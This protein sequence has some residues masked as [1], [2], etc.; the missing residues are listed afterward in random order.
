M[1]EWPS[2]EVAVTFPGVCWV[3]RDCRV[4]SGVRGRL[5][6]GGAV[7]FGCETAIELLRSAFAI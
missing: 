4:G 1:K 6:V 2:L 7:A 3:Y 5:H